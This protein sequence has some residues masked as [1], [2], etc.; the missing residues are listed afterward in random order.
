MNELRTA[1]SARR[2]LV[3]T[4]VAL[5]L[6]SIAFRL[7][8][9][10]GT[11]HT[12]LVFIGIP[13]LLALALV[14]VQPKSSAG[15]VNKAIAIALCMSGIVFGEAFI[16]IVMAS[17]LFFLIGTLA[18]YVARWQRKRTL[19]LMVILPLAFEGVFPG[20]RFP[21]EETVTVL[22]VVEADADQVRAALAAPMRFD[23][24]LPFFLR[25]GFP[26]PGATSGS[27]L[28]IGDR[29]S[30]EF[31]HDRHHTGTL[32]LEVTST[33]SDSVTFAAISDDSYLTHWLT[34]RTAEVHW[35]QVAPGQT[36][37]AWSLNYRRRLDPAWYF[38]PLEQAGVRLAAEYLLRTLSTP[39]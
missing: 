33:A 1:S 19:G 20:W 3:A 7:M 14:G 22:G 21:S 24:Q 29:R 30:I 9:A 5:T 36:M 23:A 4:I 28:A 26:T 38:K 18:T 39:R 8:R 11:E 17:P 16:C 10:T 32:V 34:W 13:A 37:V 25:L 12:S 27:G 35:S 31:L 2:T 15:T 6:V